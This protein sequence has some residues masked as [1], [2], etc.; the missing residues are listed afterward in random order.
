MRSLNSIINILSNKYSSNGMNIKQA[1]DVWKE[2]NL[3]PEQIRE[4]ISFDVREKISSEDAHLLYKVARQEDVSKLEYELYNKLRNAK[5]IKLSPSI[6]SALEKEG[7]IYRL[8]I[9][10][11]DISW[12]IELKDGTPWLKRI[13]TKNTEV[14]EEE[15][16]KQS[17]AS[18]RTK[19]AAVEENEPW[20]VYYWNSGLANKFLE[21]YP[22]VLPEDLRCIFKEMEALQQGLI[23][24]SDFL[25]RILDIADEYKDLI[26]N[27]RER[28]EEESNK[29]KDLREE[30]EKGKEP[31]YYKGASV[32]TS[33]IRNDNH[34]DGYYESDD[35]LDLE[36]LD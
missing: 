15:S 31:N 18:L 10:G 1:L 4:Q 35:E 8:K 16:L 36:M 6:K 19:K 3:S 17:D 11:V 26:K 22:G 20:E 24:E 27:I 14:V 25:I 30:Y 2:S 5:Y 21:E 9:A 29:R 7:N 28:A 12:A 23:R 34:D 32:N 13:S 33:L